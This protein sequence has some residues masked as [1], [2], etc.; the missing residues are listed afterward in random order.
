M[1]RTELTQLIIIFF[2][3]VI[4]ILSLVRNQ[5]VT[6]LTSLRF[7]AITATEIESQRA[8]KKELVVLLINMSFVF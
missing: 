3:T 6:Q 8:E 1:S 5:F 4:K 2:F 7:P